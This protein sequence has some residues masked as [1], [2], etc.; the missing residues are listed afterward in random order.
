MIVSCSG[1][2]VEYAI[3]EDDRYRLDIINSNSR[4]IIITLSLNV[5]AKMYDISKAKNNCSTTKG[6][7]QL[8]L[9]FPYT[10]YVI[11]TTPSNVR[12]L[13]QTLFPILINTLLY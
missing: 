7:C 8:K 4:S 13:V 2:Q 3:E 1:K 11:L 9:L 5:S 6:S 10:H 12:L